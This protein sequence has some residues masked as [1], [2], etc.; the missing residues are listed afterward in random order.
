MARK[1]LLRNRVRCKK[2]GDTIESK[3]THDHQACKCGAVSVDGGL[4][5]TRVL[6]EPK[7][8]ETLYHWMTLS[9]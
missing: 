1:I 8:Y 7:D 5:Y 6:G 3:T 2:C 9:R 4:S